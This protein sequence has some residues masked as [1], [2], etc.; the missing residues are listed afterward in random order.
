M[1]VAANCMY[2]PYLLHRPY[3]SLRR[4]G[5]M[6]DPL[7]DAELLTIRAMSWAAAILTIREVLFRNYEWWGELR[8]EWGNWVMDGFGVVVLFALAY[9]Q[10]PLFYGLSSD[11]KGAASEVAKK[12]RSEA[13]IL[14]EQLLLTRRSCGRQRRTPLSLPRI[15]TATAG[16]PPLATPELG[17]Q[18]R[19]C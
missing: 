15:S 9:S 10:L 7:N 1:F 11:M 17:S 19:R 5:R 18:S 3:V 13:T 14:H 12:V 6:G 2:V 8:T 4:S 16:T